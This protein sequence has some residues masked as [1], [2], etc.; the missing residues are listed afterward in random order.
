MKQPF[1]GPVLRERDG[2]RWV[3][4]LLCHVEQSR[5]RDNRENWAC[6]LWKSRMETRV[7]YC[8][9]SY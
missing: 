1:P 9:S 5:A 3:L 4:T 8:D 2:H 7:A 6:T